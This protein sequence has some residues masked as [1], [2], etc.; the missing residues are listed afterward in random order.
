M[1]VVN[2]NHGR[3]RGRGQGIYHGRGR[4]NYYYCGGRS[5]NLN[6]KRTRR[7]NDH[8]VKA[9]QNKHSKSDE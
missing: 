7:N 3:D 2:F 9:S 6:F 1:N 5:N 8:K 4:D